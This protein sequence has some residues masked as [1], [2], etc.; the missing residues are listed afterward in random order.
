VTA[1]ADGL[2][3]GTSLD[4]WMIERKLGQGGMGAVYLARHAVLGNTAVIKVLKPALAASADAVTRFVREAKAA[5]AVGS[6][7]I[8]RAMDFGVSPDGTAYL[9]MEH[10]EGEDLET[11]L[12]RQGALP[13]RRACEIALQIL[14]GLGAAH[15]AGIVHRDVKPAN[16]FV[17]REP[18][19]GAEVIKLLDFGISK[20]IEGTSIEVL[21]RTGMLMGTPVYMAPEQFRSAH[22]VDPRADLWSVGVILYRMLGGQVPYDGE[23][24]EQLI[25]RVL[26]E[27]PRSLA[28]VAAHVPPSLVA[29]VDRALA[30]EPAHRWQSA[31]E[32]AAAIRG[33]TAMPQFAT[34]PDFAGAGPSY[35]P[36]PGP[37]PIGPSYA[38]PPTAVQA[39]SK[40]TE[41]AV[42]A[43]SAGVGLAVVLMYCVPT[44]LTVLLIA[45]LIAFQ[46]W[47]ASR[48]EDRALELQEEAIRNQDL[49]PDE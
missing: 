7:H 49:D 15:R 14:A 3:P 19:S 16:V 21:T 17:A 2:A 44:L 46:L 1:H 26:T 40:G 39:Q 12:R 20:V 30:R 4:R 33:S 24:L 41:R 25:L 35:T 28:V 29:V 18:G 10:L 23:T 38:P 37:V 6:P 48:A 27:P 42:V 31:D 11:L 8:A 45:G 47:Q 5:A 9:V 34:R 36:P 43:A 13:P 22:L 32:M